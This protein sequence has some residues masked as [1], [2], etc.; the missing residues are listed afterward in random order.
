MKDAVATMGN[1]LPDDAGGRDAVH[2]AVFSATTPTRLERR[3][4]AE[5]EVAR[6]AELLTDEIAREH[7]KVK[8]RIEETRESI[9]RGAR[10][11]GKRFHL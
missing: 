11:P 3:R 5:T 10:R 9:K 8:A 2:V 1:L 6:L 4:A 7:A